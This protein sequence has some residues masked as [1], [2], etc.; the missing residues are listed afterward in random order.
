MCSGQWL[1]DEQ[2]GDQT[3]PTFIRSIVL[4][5]AQRGRRTMNHVS[6]MIRVR[7]ADE[8]AQRRG[9]NII[10]MAAGLHSISLLL[11]IYVIFAGLLSTRFLISVAV[12][13]IVQTIVIVLAWRGS[14]DLAGGMLVGMAIV[15]LTGAAFFNNDTFVT[16]I[17]LLLPLLMAAAALRPVWI[18]VA[19]VGVLTGMGVIFTMPSPAE[20]A[21]LRSAIFAVT[22]LM[23]L[24]T[25]LTGVLIGVGHAHLRRRL[26]DE[27]KRA[28]RAKIELQI[29]NE[30]LDLRVQ[31]QT[32]ALQQTLQELEQQTLR[33]DQLLKEIAG[34]REIIREL[35]LPILPV[36]REVLVAP[37][38]GALD[39]E[40]MQQLQSQVL[41][42][43]ER[44][45]ARLLIL[46]VTGVP[47][48]DTHVAQGLM[49][50][51]RGLR[52]LGANVALVG[53]RPEVAQTI[54]ALGVQLRDIEVFSDL[55]SALQRAVNRTGARRDFSNLS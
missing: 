38:I 28:D 53:V 50:L 22:G 35:S 27:M 29:L 20:T 41:K 21:A 25:T 23:S 42:R 6:K 9:F 51:V 48:I 43:V 1:R 33:Q 45:H 36:G 31:M 15:G 2:A 17:F 3:T 34:Q 55:G 44:I 40:R 19:L 37:L 12:S 46:D 18:I 4:A 7:H 52:L 8:D 32:E 24:F 14:V 54:V 30:E 10:L 13:V 49:N 11:T 26:H 16:P 47:I 39:Q 5:I